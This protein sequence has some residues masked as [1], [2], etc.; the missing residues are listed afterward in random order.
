MYPLFLTRRS[1][2]IIADADGRRVVRDDAFIAPIFPLSLAAGMAGA[3]QEP[4]AVLQLLNIVTDADLVDP[5]VVSGLKEDVRRECE[6]FGPIE[7]VEIP[8]LGALGQGRVC[9]KC[10]A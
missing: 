6:Q 8:A 7:E 10:G 9:L 4:T 1:S 2:F 3:P 5:G